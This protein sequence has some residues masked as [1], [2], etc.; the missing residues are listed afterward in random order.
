MTCETLLGQKAVDEL[1]DVAAKDTDRFQ[2]TQSQQFPR[3]RLFC[4]GNERCL[5]MAAP[6]RTQSAK[7]ALGVRI[8]QE[9]L[10]L[11]GSSSRD[12]SPCLVPWSQIALMVCGTPRLESS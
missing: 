8:F 9:P 1:R 3:T 6:R 7:S 10:H 11:Q 5:Y 4:F 2:M 12:S